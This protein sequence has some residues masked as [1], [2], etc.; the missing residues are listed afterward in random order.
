MS[1]F[2]T[3]ALGG[4]VAALVTSG[5]SLFAVKL[6]LDHARESDRLADERRLRDGRSGRIRTSIETMLKASL[7]VG[8]VVKESETLL[9]HEPA[10]VRDARHEAMLNENLIGLNEARVSLMLYSATKD[11]VKVVDEDI[12]SSYQ[13]YRDTYLFNKKHPDRDHHRELGEEYKKLQ[14]GIE[15]LRTEGVRVLE[16][17]GKPI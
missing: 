14:T 6:G 12:L 3:A 7:A 9:Q 1:P 8:Q 16:E 4:L 10:D 2:L 13:S 11:L 17:M 15:K 5:I